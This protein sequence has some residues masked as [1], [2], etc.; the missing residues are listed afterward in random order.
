LAKSTGKNISG[1][2]KPFLLSWEKGF[3]G[4]LFKLRKG[5]NSR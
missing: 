1:P 5:I 3:S 2:E 4:S